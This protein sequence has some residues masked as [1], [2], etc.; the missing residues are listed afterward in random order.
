MFIDNT[1]RSNISQNYKN[2]CAVLFSCY[3]IFKPFYF[4]ESGLPQLSDYFI[5]LLFAMSL[6]NINVTIR[7][8]SADKISKKLTI[9]L[10][11][12]LY[13]I[14]FVN[15]IW[16]MI[17]EGDLIVSSLWYL[18]NVLLLFIFLFMYYIF[19]NAIYSIVYKSLIFTVSLQV[20]LIFFYIEDSHRGTLF[21]NNPNQLGYFGLLS[22]GIILIIARIEKVRLPGL[23]IGIASSIA[24]ILFSL[25]NAAIIS[26]VIILILFIWPSRDKNRI[27]KFFSI[28]TA[29]CLLCSFFI[30]LFNPGLVEKIEIINKMNNRLIKATEM[31]SEQIQ[32]RRYNIITENKKYL[33]FGAGE[34]NFRE[35]FNSAGEI[36]S[37]VGTIVFSYG[38]IGLLLFLLILFRVLYRKNLYNYYPVIAILLYGFTHNGIRNG[39]L[40]ITLGVIFTNRPIESK[41]S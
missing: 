32:Y 35:R 29:L 41:Y 36:H 3:F 37:T 7:S 27:F 23:I 9:L 10:I 39:L 31:G 12:F 14:I 1:L 2:I 20:L 8:V 30:Y 38:I 33:V 17:I 19:G 21:F 15:G 6:F 34:G 4:F 25:S 16:S 18:F 13:N 11:L 24:L 22:L 26:S 28:F 5:L 40:W